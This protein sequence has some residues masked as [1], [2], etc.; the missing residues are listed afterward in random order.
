M[1][2]DI[3]ERNVENESV[4]KVQRF[5]HEPNET[6]SIRKSVTGIDQ[7]CFDKVAWR[8]RISKREWRSSN[9]LWLMVDGRACAHRCGRGYHRYFLRQTRSHDGCQ[10]HS[11][12]TEVKRIVNR[13]DSVRKGSN[14]LRR[15][16]IISQAVRR[17]FLALVSTADV[18][19]KEKW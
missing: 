9:R 3:V 15:F 17:L 6:F 16:Q 7:S 5:T 8:V 13:V 2:F 4:I 10:S 12:A 11:K 18:S 1:T 19:I 14:Q